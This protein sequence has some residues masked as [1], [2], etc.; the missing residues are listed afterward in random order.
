VV[1]PE[2]P[3]GG[4]L[5][6]VGRHPPVDAVG[7]VRAKVAERHDGVTLGDDEAELHRAVDAEGGQCRSGLGDVD[8]VAQR[9]QPH[10]GGAGGRGG[11]RHPLRGQRLVTVEGGER[12]RA[13]Q[14]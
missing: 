7:G 12:H 14:L 3:A 8:G 13:E 9:E 10:Q 6:E 4:H 11:R 2:R 5:A 1:L